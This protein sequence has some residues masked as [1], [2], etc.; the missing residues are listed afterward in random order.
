MEDIDPRI[1]YALR[2]VRR[3]CAEL[4][5]K[6]LVEAAQNFLVYMDVVRRIYER[7]TAEGRDVEKVTEEW[8]NK[9]HRD[10]RS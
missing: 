9:Q 2:L 6:E 7:L 8:K 4:S 5:E 1:P 10:P 3:W